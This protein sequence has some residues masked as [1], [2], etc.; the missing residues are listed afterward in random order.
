MFFFRASVLLGAF[1]FSC[2]LFSCVHVYNLT[3]IHPALVL[4]LDLVTEIAQ[5]SR[6]PFS[7]DHLVD[8]LPHLH[9]HGAHQRRRTAQ[10]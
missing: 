1:L 2:A 4:V 8:K 7:Q 5:L 3:L 10:L 9:S 6:K